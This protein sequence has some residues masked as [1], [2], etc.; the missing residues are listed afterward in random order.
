MLVIVATAVI[1]LYLVLF[2]HEFFHGWAAI[3]QGL[4]IEAFVFGLPLV[5][6]L[7]F[8]TQI[9]GVPFIFSPFIIGLGVKI[10]DEALWEAGFRKPAVVLLYGP[11]GSLIF[12]T[13]I[14]MLVSGPSLGIEQS[15]ELLL[16]SV[17]AVKLVLV[18]QVSPEYAVG[19][20]GFI[21]LTTWGMKADF[22]MGLAL[23]IMLLNFAVAVVSL[24]P[25]PGLDGGKLMFIFAYALTGKQPIVR[26]IAYKG[27]LVIGSILIIGVLLLTIK[28]F[29][30]MF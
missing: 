13:M 4:K 25:L 9:R 15:R 22:G 2:V 23:M 30:N 17:E 27:Q 24:L 19:P 7:T 1:S 6:R 8:K 28:D 29:A 12:G 3:R 20:A 21:Q 14:A 5:K 10:E 11:A 16:G 18:G 26:K